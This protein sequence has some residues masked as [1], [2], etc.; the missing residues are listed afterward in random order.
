MT[1]TSR[2]KCR[3]FVSHQ[4]QKRCPRFN[5][6]K[7][8]GERG[9][10]KVPKAFGTVHLRGRVSR[11]PHF[12]D[13][14]TGRPRVKSLQKSRKENSRKDQDHPSRRTRGNWS[15]FHRNHRKDQDRPS[16]RTRGK[17]SRFRGKARNISS[18]RSS[19]IVAIGSRRA[20][21]IDL[22]EGEI[23]AFRGPGIRKTKERDACIAI[24]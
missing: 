4:I 2:E 16:R 7:S 22:S 15:A 10:I 3:F 5:P 12:G 19:G 11:D 17:R 24:P 13:S 20:W 21:A 6:R 14:D 18:R 8:R 23:S 1:E 9:P